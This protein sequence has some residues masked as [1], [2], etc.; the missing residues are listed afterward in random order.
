M[1][2]P[3]VLN[4]AASSFFNDVYTLGNTDH[5]DQ[6]GAGSSRLTE[7]EHHSQASALTLMLL[8]NTMTKLEIYALKVVIF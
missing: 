7:L 2:Y 3:Q 8:S 5:L 4:Q 1:F 6:N